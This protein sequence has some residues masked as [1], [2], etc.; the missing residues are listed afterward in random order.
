MLTPEFSITKIPSS[1]LLLIVLL[2]TSTCEALMILTPSRVLLLRVLLST[3]A[4]E[5]RPTKTPSL[6]LAAAPPLPVMVLEPPGTPASGLISA[7]EL[8]FTTI[9]PPVLLL[10]V[11]PVI[12]AL[13]DLVTTM[14]APSLFRMMLGLLKVPGEPLRK[15]M[16]TLELSVTKI[17][18]D[19]FPEIVFPSILADDDSPTV[20]PLLPLF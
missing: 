20:I 11:L 2:E 12:R 1:P 8:S 7:A 17:P 19:V 13:E 10:I 5:E 14:P 9:P 16:R 6:A 3:V 18:S 4:D 15:P